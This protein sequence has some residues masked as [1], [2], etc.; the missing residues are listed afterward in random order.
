MP[1][2]TSNAPLA[3]LNG[4]FVPAAEA[5]V[6][7]TD[8]GFVL[9][10]T[11]SEQLRTLGGKLFALDEHLARLAGSL[12]VVGVPLP[13]GWPQLREAAEELAA[14]NRALLAEGDDLGLTIVVTPGIY[15]TYRDDA[16]AASSLASG[17]TLCLHTYPLPFRLWADKYERG[18]ALATTS[19]QQVSAACWPRHVKIR[20]RLHYYLADRQAAAHNPPARAL[21]LDAA[22]HVTETAAANVLVYRRAVGLL[23]PRYDSILPGISLGCLTTLCQAHGIA[24]EERDLTPDDVAAA[25][26]VLLASTPYCLLP[27]TRFN[28]RPIGDGRPGE[29]FR[30][31]LA[32]WSAQSGLDIAA[33]AKRFSVRQ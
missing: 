3:Y 20:S 1:H 31:L 4:R 16:S 17:P 11:A 23:S 24:L 21:L 13:V 18:E 12:Q 29:V 14:H 26:E 9:G 22:G 25:D 33:Q 19:I 32:A 5:V 27:V 30:K 28:D 7:V 15:A 10:V 8:A 2:I 6:P